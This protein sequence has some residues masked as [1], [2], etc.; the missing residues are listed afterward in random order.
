MWPWTSQDPGQLE[1]GS[2]Y[3]DDGADYRRRRRNPCAWH[4]GVPVSVIERGADLAKNVG[5]LG[6][7]ATS[8]TRSRSNTGNR[9]LDCF[10]D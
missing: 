3:G 5:H 6:V 8:G 10:E 9:R 1:N 7:I 2:V 4:G